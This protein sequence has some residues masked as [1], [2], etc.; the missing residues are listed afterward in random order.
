MKKSMKKMLFI[1]IAL[2]LTVALSGCSGDKKDEDLSGV[3]D[4]S[5][6]SSASDENIIEGGTVVVGIQQDL[7]SLDPHLAVAAGTE[8]VLFNVFEGLVKPDEEGNLVS[9]VASDYKLS[10]DGKTY[11]FTLREG[12]KFHNGAPVTV[13]DIKYSIDRCAGKLD[14][15]VLIPAYSVIDSVNIIDDSTVEVVLSESDTEL[16][17]YMT[18][19]IL[20]EG[21]EDQ[22]T[23][24]VG[25]GPFQFVSYSP[26]E[27]FIVE[28]FEDYWGEKAHLDRVE[29]KIV[30]NTDSAALDLRAGSIDIYPY[31]T[32][33]QATELAS[34][35][36]IKQ[37][38]M[39]LI[40]GL[41]LNNGCELFQDERVR[42]AMCYA[43][44]SDEINQIVA[45]GKGTPIGSN[46]FPGFEKYYMPE[47]NDVY[48]YNI[49]EAKE[50][51]EEAGYPDGFDLTIKVPSNYQFH[52]DTAQVIVEQLKQ[53]GIRATIEQVEW[54]TWLSDVY[55]GRNYEA[56][57]IGLDGNLAP[58]DI[59]ERFGSTASN[60]FINYSNPEYDAVLKEAIE[61]TDENVKIEKYKMLEEMLTEDAASVYLLDPP[62]LVA[63]NKKLGGYTFYPVYVQDL[64]KVYFT[65]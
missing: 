2:M 24:P 58:K 57:I 61:T 39:N 46:M 28:K 47:L 15:N 36:D 9:A 4:M 34:V 51:L 16:I 13:N 48:P 43:I 5:S 21:Y 29:F 59:L 27:S 10:E 53:A 22:A 41:F 19:A 56:T 38:N 64:S 1:C 37:G 44:S 65:E 7:D 25:T 20:P 62:N 32:D 23:A 26:Q 60:N 14:G 8:E 45:G 17:A 50:L 42:K 40:Q 33:D 31:L 55:Q 35:M 30:A 18:A 52:V 3:D 11:T 12:V 49:E 54:T 63:V 6:E